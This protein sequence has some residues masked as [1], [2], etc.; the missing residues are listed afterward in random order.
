[1]AVN[2]K[3]SHSSLIDYR[4]IKPISCPIPPQK[5]AAKRHYGSHPYFTKRA[6]NVV[7]EYIRTFAPNQ[8]D[9]V[10]DPF[11]GSGVTA[12]EAL[13]LRRKAIHVDINPFANFICRQVAV[14]PVSLSALSL[15]FQ[16]VE[17]ACKARLERLRRLSDKEL[18]NEPIPY[19]YPQGVQ[20]PR[21]AD[22]ATVEEL[23]T[24]RQLI[25]L[26]I[27][28]Q[29]I[30]DQT[31]DTIR[32][33]LLF[34]FSATLAKVNRTFVSAQNRAESR[35]GA[36]I[37]SVY[38]YNVPSQPVE[39]DVW[40]QFA[41]R[42]THLMKA[43]RETNQLIGDY[44]REGET[45]QIHQQSATQ[46]SEFIPSESVDYIYTDPPY[47]AHIAYLG[48]STMWNAWLDFPVRD[49]DYALEVIEGG[50]LNKSRE[51]YESLLRQSI[52][53]MCK[54]LKPN[55]WLSLVFAHKDPAYWNTIVEAAQ[56]AGLEYCN[57]VVQPAGVVWSMHKKKNPLT[58]LSGELV[59]NFRKVAKP[60]RIKATSM[61][62][63]ALIDFIRNAAELSIVRHD[64][65]TTEQIY[66]DL[67][68]TLLENG[69]LSDARQ[70]LGDVTPI[71]R[72]TFV[73]DASRKIWLLKSGS[74]AGTF[75]PFMERVRFYVT[76]YLRKS[77]P[78][79]A[80]LEDIITSVTPNLVNGDTPSPEAIAKV[81]KQIAHSHNGTHWRLKPESGQT[82]L[83]L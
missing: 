63:A 20:L 46:L 43:K 42:F 54:V 23:F 8:G 65:A 9:V 41:M 73:F 14:A 30:Q 16:E 57:T 44:Y 35:G 66:Y 49:E 10:C 59:L 39:L 61:N 17:S 52:A 29:H 79:G 32:S 83:P 77:A 5:Q 33:L 58:V 75:V 12:V 1:M 80:T 3:S 6:W 78:T 82:T 22:V 62:G 81:V 26:S 67:I 31:D 71:L 37:F 72:E 34:V 70:Q 48:L 64:G 56:D 19:W 69:L 60:K 38:R 2:T 25:S 55:R 51:E 11:G 53:E 4:S 40:E 15:A 27:L 50:D 74:D 13:I 18:T 24:R 76:A 28:H 47:G 36:T 7:R 68:P 21:N 45:F